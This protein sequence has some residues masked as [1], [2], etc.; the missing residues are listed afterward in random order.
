MA[1]VQ[2]NE[3]GGSGEG[4]KLRTNH[5]IELAREFIFKTN[6]NIFLTGKAGTGKTTFLR[7]I[8]KSSGKR[9]VVA[10]P[11]GVAALNAGGV[12]LH[13]LFQLP[14]GPLVPGVPH[15]GDK[16]DLSSVKR[17]IVRSMELLIIDEISMVRCDVLDKI[18]QRLRSVRKSNRP[19]GGV[20]LLLIGDVQQLAPICRDDEWSMLSNHYNSPYFFDA[21][22]LRNK[23]YVTIELDEIFRQR[24]SKFTDILN[25]IR[26]NRATRA[27][28]DE[29]NKRYIENF[30]APKGEEYITL[31]THNTHANSINSRNLNDLHSLPYFYDAD[32]SGDFPESAYPN[33]TRLELKVGAQ[34]MFIKNDISNAKE[35][36]NGMLGQVVSLDDSSV[37]VKPKSGAKE[38]VVS[39][40]SWENLEYNINSKSGEMM[41]NVKGTFSQIP[42]KCAWAITIHKSQGLSFDNAIIDAAGSFAHGQV[43]VALSRCRT[44]EGMVL[45]RPIPASSIIEELNVEQFNNYVSSNQPTQEDLD[46]HKKI[47]FTTVICD[48]YDYEALQKILWELMSEMT[49]VISKTHTNLT[50]S[51]IDYLATFE[52]EIGAIGKGFQ[53]HLRRAVEASEDYTKDDHIIERLRS[54]AAYFK[55]RLEVAYSLTNE[56]RKID[57]DAELTRKKVNTL[58]R[59]ILSMLALQQSDFAICESG[60]NIEEYH[61][62]RANA[63]ALDSINSKEDSNQSSSSTKGLSN[64]S[65]STKSAPLGDLVHEKLYKRLLDWRDEKSRQFAKRTHA[66]LS[67]KMLM[68]I[69]NTLPTTPNGLAAIHGLG[70]VKIKQFGSEIIKIVKDYCAEEGVDPF[71]IRDL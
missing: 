52:K 33:D 21:L 14:F 15:M 2:S 8:V 5:K 64:S 35:Y 9:A 19:F 42:L 44:L 59:S 18:E 1:T 13:S 6:T 58:T 48:M 39:A 12:T 41:Q 51:L 40:I 17:A 32:V 16:R 25:A 7:E 56:I 30:V 28:L 4:E 68:Q 43:Y 46:K 71:K 47:Y 34:V 55:P 70:R 69:Q 45:K 31:T 22:S 29:L 37:T 36:Y 66:V 60:F 57:I 62:I 50:S 23:S 11:T 61:S 65:S 63:L 26:E 54:A 20:Q 3:S 27:T 10:A 24:D 67:V 49:G 38:I 53:A